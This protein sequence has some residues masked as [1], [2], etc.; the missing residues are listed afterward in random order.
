MNACCTFTGRL[1]PLH[2]VFPTIDAFICAKQH[3]N[4]MMQDMPEVPR[5][6]IVGLFPTQC[7]AD[8][9]TGRVPDRIAW[10]YWHNLFYSYVHKSEDLLVPLYSPETKGFEIYG[11]LSESDDYFSRYIAAVGEWVQHQENRGP[12]SR[13]ATLKELEWACQRSHFTFEIM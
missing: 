13:F 7:C 2:V 11:A 4:Q 1:A 6:F 10:D 8:V 9:P 12:T 3:L 5:R